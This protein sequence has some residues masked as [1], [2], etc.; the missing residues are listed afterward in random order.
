V[1]EPSIAFDKRELGLIIR[2]FKAMSEQAQEEGKKIGYDLAQYAAQ[3]VRKT[4]L[5]RTVNPVAVRRIADGVVV[6]RT[7]K[8]GE[9]KYGFA[10]QRFSGGGSTKTLWAGFEFGSSR[11]RQ[12]PTRTPRVSG[13]GNFGYFIHPTL[14]RIQPEL[15]RQWLEGMDRVIKKWE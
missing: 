12:F 1:T 3:E 8:I 9:L 10:S 15:V 13:R 11:Y 14:R 7:S 6:S 5:T 2:A 4:A